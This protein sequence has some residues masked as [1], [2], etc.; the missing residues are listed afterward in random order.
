MS[1]RE[2]FDSIFESAVKAALS[3]GRK[4]DEFKLL[5]VSKTYGADTVQEAVDSGIFLFGENKVQEARDKI[6][7]L[8]GNFE[9]HLIGHLQSNKAKDAVKLFSTIHSIDKITTAEKLDTEAEKINKTIEVLVQVNTSGEDSKSG[10][11]PDLAEELCSQI[12]LSSN[13][14]L[15][16]LMTIGP[17]GGSLPDA[18]K[19]FSLLRNLK[20]KINSSLS[21]NMAELS[22]GMSGD[23][24]EAI[25]EGATI[26][27]VG[28]AIF[29]KRNY[30]NG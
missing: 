12:M 9:F 17:A 27:R 10:V 21:I 11:I 23:Y 13:L 8:R 7:L 30:T 1:I 20:E 22:M 16:G 26:I 6:P 18:I 15:T 3:S 14:K 25:K 19:S 5:S 28:S 29:G 2:N 4:S 24:I